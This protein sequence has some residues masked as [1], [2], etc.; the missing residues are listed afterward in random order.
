M[1]D[2]IVIGDLAPYC[3]TIGCHGSESEFLNTWRSYSR[4]ASLTVQFPL[5]P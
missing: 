4:P 5:Q 3:L 2:Q 1:I